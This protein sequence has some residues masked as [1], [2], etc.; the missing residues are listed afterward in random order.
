MGKVVELVRHSRHKRDLTI[1]WI[2]VL[3]MI[4][5]LEV[6]LFESMPRKRNASA[7]TTDEQMTAQIRSTALGLNKECDVVEESLNRER[8][9]VRVGRNGPG[10]RGVVDRRKGKC[11]ESLCDS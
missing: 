11:R 7:K 10:R 3:R 4:V 9:Q 6:Q 8:L 5:S 2:V 1:L